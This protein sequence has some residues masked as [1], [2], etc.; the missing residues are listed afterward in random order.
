L[1]STYKLRDRGNLH[2]TVQWIICISESL[3]EV[4]IWRI[5]LYNWASWGGFWYWWYCPSTCGGW[6]K[7]RCSENWDGYIAIGKKK[8]K[9]KKDKDNRLENR[10][11]HVLQWWTWRSPQCA[12]PYGFSEGKK[13]FCSIWFALASM[14]IIRSATAKMNYI[15]HLSCYLNMVEPVEVTRVYNGNLRSQ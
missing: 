14:I 5:V 12:P 8:M 3:Q 15:L 10:Q 11:R 9:L 13:G 4:C 1:S 6:S 2:S 7:G